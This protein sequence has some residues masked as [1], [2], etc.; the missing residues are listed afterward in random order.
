[1]IQRLA[2]RAR[3]EVGDAG[4]YAAILKRL[5]DDRLTRVGEEYVRASKNYRLTDKPRFIDKNNLNWMHIGLILLA[6]P[7]ARI[8]DVRREPLDC[9]WANFKML[10]A[11]GFP[12][13]NDLAHVGKFYADYV[14]LLDAMAVA[15]PGRIL[16]VRY[17]SVVDNAE[18]QLRRMVDFLG[19]PFE[20]QCLEFHLSTDAVATASSEQVRQPLNRSGVDRWK[21]YAQWLQPLRDALGP[22]AHA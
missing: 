11:D 10:F 5:P 14:R 18:T 22:L 16:Q 12:A 6:L 3:H 17:E 21:P 19:L 2:E 4:E 13:T 8:L 15:A 1:M 9:C 20:V 7:N